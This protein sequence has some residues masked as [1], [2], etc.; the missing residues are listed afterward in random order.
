[1]QPQKPCIVIA[2]FKKKSKAGGTT[3]LDF[4]LH[5]KT[6]VIKAAFNWHKAL[7]NRTESKTQK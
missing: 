4:K 5:Y 3:M 2:I 7:I 6:V 1:M